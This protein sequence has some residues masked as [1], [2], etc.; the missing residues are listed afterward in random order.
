MKGNTNRLKNVNPHSRKAVNL[1][2][3][4]TPKTKVIQSNK[5]NMLT[6]SLNIKQNKDG[7][8]E[9]LNRTALQK[10]G[11]KEEF[12]KGEENTIYHNTQTHQELSPDTADNGDNN[13]SLQL[14]MTMSGFN[15]HNFN[16]DSPN[17]KK[18]HYSMVS[19]NPIFGTANNFNT[20]SADS[21][22]GGPFHK[23]NDSKHKSVCTIN[24]I[25]Y[26]VYN[27]NSVNNI[28]TYN[29]N[30]MATYNPNSQ[31]EFSSIDKIAKFHLSDYAI[32]EEI[33]SSTFGKQYLV[34]EKTS[35]K[36]FTMLKII[37]AGNK[38]L[39]KLF[40]FYELV[41]KYQHES[42]QKAYAINISTVDSVTFC[43]SVL[44]ESFS[45]TLESHVHFMKEN[46]QFYSENDL[47]VFLKQTISGLIFLKSK[48]TCHGHINPKEMYVN[49]DLEKQD[50]FAVKLSIPFL[51]D[52]LKWS[53]SLPNL[54]RD[55][56]KRNELYLSPLLYSNV[57]RNLYTKGHDPVKSDVYSLGLCMLYA[58]CMTQKPFFE[59]KTK[60]D[61]EGVKKVVSKY[62]TMKY[63][64]KFIELISAMLS[65][66]EKKR[67][68]YQK[69]M[70]FAEEI[71]NEK[72][73]SIY[74]D[75]N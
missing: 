29:P 72:R 39:E 10:K 41:Y 1:Y 20:I 67:W 13:Q 36:Q 45:T 33:E 75:R 52:P 22:K 19:P 40:S 60:Y 27:M 55:K 11:S 57:T 54:V 37:L 12:G 3:I 71:L 63:S 23:K 26:N 42:I 30:L 28:H 38:P 17:S 50:E 18:V 6:K 31:Q 25:N 5:E 16:K 49:N 64:L 56:L 15:K 32:L 4:S 24:N 68:P 46:K 70:S 74:T 35:N 69:I 53:F 62:L 48:G 59:L 73:E 51:D 2:S 34:Q 47:L 65:S 21:A 14:S 58:A 9:V 66:D 61:Q 43:L 44:T 8:E 7:R